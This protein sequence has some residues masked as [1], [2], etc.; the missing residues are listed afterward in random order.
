MTEAAFAD[1]MR[2]PEDGFDAMDPANV[3]PLVAWLC[4]SESRHV[5][6]RMFEV[7]GGKIILSDGWRPGATVD[8]GARWEQSEIGDAVSSLLAEAPAPMPVYGA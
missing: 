2:A 1:M 4:G 8:K 3:A 6:G 5:T 7:S